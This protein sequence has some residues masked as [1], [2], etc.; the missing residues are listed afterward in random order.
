M[1]AFTFKIKFE[2]KEKEYSKYYYVL[3]NLNQL[4][5][6]RLSNFMTMGQAAKC[7]KMSTRTYQGLVSGTQKSMSIDC[8]KKIKNE[9]DHKIEFLE[10][11]N[12]S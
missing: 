5:T 2:K 3:S 9:T 4:E 10:L 12:V 11:T 6:W 7:F 1:E 8:L